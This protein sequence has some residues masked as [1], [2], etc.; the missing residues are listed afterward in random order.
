VSGPLPPGPGPSGS[1]MVALLAAIDAALAGA[2]DESGRVA[3]VRRYIGVA[4]EMGPAGRRATF[5]VIAR[6][7]SRDISQDKP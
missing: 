3:L 4:L 6:M 7:I 2:H 1:G 5:T